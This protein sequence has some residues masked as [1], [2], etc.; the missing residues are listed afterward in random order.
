[1]LLKL[2]SHSISPM[3]REAKL[4]AARCRT[5]THE[6]RA[7]E[8]HDQKVPSSARRAAGLFGFLIFS[9]RFDRPD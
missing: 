8:K 7:S 5:A 9:H 3:L 2:E 4:I 6:A 1:M